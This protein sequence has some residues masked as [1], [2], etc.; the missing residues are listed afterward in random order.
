MSSPLSIVFAG[1]PEFSVPTLK[2][3]AAS[4]HRVVAV[5]TQPDRPAGRGR[6]VAISDVK[7]LGLRLALP[8]EQPPTL[9]EPSSVTRLAAYRPD[10]MIVV[11]YG[12]LLPESVLQVPRLGCINIHASLLPRWRGAAP[13][14]RAVEAGDPMTGVTIMRMDA[15]LDTGPMLLTETTAI[16]ERD[17]AGA[18]HDRLAQ[19]G[20]TVL[21]E[22]LDRLA[23][24]TLVAE[25]QPL[26]G[27]TYAAKIKKEEA[28]IDWTKSAAEIDRRVRA[29]SPWPIAETRWEGQQLRIWESVVPGRVSHLEPGSVV[30]A[31]NEGIDV[32]T[33]VGC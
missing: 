5:Y 10:V 18:V 25:P 4:R 16:S 12:L 2:A 15:G 33:G 22:A 30:A 1:T 31:T 26:E 9:R 14:Q 23:S 29:F 32:A 19:L 8:I 3:L 21:L 13:I 7:R 20:A 28:V 17:T 11:A 27:A 24:G 6:Q